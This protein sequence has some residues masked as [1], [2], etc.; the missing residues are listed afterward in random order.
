MISAMSYRPNRPLGNILLFLI[1]VAAVLLPG[2]GRGGGAPAA[3][4]TAGGPSGAAADD[5][6]GGKPA[7]VPALHFEP[8]TGDHSD[9]AV[10]ETAVDRVALIAA[11]P[12]DW[13]TVEL[14]VHC[15]CMTARYV[16]TPTPTRAEVEITFH[17]EKIEKIEASIWAEDAKREKL[18]EY[19][20]P[21]DARRRPFV[22]PRKVTLEKG[23]SGRVEFHLGQA[24]DLKAKPPVSVLD[25]VTYDTERWSPIDYPVQETMT[26]EHQLR[27][28]TAIFELNESARASPSTSKFVFRFGVPPVE[29]TVEVF[30][31]GK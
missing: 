18:A 8:A 28:C 5:G 10:F 24:F 19:S 4:S 6:A 17:T 29:R 25:D 15:E 21:V 11:A 3:P 23:G 2:C 26:D 9:L 20:A 30:W 27:E 16:G 12:V 22:E 13:K 14:V 31:P 7:A 1:P